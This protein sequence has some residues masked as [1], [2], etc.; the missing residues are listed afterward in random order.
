MRNFVLISQT[1]AEIWRDFD[2]FFKMA[3][4]CY[5][6]FVIRMLRPPTKN[7][8]GL[9]HC[10]KF[11]WDQCCS[12]DNMKVLIFCTLGLKMLSHTPKMFF[13]EM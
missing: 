2:F 12:F 8:G 1:I 7:F 11:G 3:A 9:D 10:A 6:G 13:L 4:V 5:L